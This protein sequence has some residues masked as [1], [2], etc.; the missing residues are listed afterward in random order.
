MRIDENAQH[1]SNF[2]HLNVVEPPSTI[3]TDG[4]SASSDSENP[5]LLL[6]LQIQIKYDADSD[7]DSV[8]NPEK[9]GL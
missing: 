1:V 2:L 8:S 7:I 4:E 5:F 6:D 9:K 3:S